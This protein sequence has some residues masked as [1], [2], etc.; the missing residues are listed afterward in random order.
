MAQRSPREATPRGNLGHRCQK[1]HRAVGYRRWG[2]VDVDDWR[3]GVARD[4]RSAY[5]FR[6]QSGA[7]YR[8]AVY[9]YAYCV[10]TEQR[11]ALSTHF[12]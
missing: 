8:M 1:P 9:Y 7:F 11:I 5:V 2:R 3:S 10:Y 4:R 6:E 12:A